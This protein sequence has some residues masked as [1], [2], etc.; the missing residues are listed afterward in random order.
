MDWKPCID[1]KCKHIAST[2]TTT[3]KTAVDIY[4]AVDICSVVDTYSLANTYS[5]VDIVVEVAMGTDSTPDLLPTFHTFVIVVV[6][7]V[8]IP[9][10]AIPCLN[11]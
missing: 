1:F 10:M 11:S 5:V 8:I 9:A 3:D 2:T 7:V 4:W 6:V